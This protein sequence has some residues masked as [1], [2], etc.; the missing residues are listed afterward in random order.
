M[1]PLAHAAAAPG[2]SVSAPPLPTASTR[3]TAAGFTLGHGTDRERLTGVTVILCPDGATAAALV[4]GSA[5]GT[6]QFDSLISP[7]HVARQ[8]HALVLAG[9]S[10]YG[11]GAA[12]A[13]VEHLRSRGKGFRTPLGIVPL[14]PKSQF[15]TRTALGPPSPYEAAGPTAGLEMVPPPIVSADNVGSIPPRTAA[16]E[17]KADLV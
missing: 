3:L 5:T 13:V 12:D 6:R 2:P 4:R 9:G 17:R 7:Q 15:F 10:G 11:L 8:A 1:A 14:V 16:A